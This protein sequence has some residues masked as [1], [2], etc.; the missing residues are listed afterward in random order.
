VQCQAHIF[1]LIKGM[2]FLEAIANIL[3]QGMHSGLFVHLGKQRVWSSSWMNTT[4]ALG[5]RGNCRGM[6]EEDP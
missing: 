1:S 4:K 6:L 3:R 2:S 5:R